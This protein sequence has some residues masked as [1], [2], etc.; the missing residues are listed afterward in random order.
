ML[1]GF[2]IQTCPTGTEIVGKEAIVLGRSKIVV[3]PPFYVTVDT[4]DMLQESQLK[5]QDF[6]IQALRSGV[7][8]KIV[9]LPEQN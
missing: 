9:S 8:V 4:P 1:C 5:F 3:S 6:K 2:L 7:L